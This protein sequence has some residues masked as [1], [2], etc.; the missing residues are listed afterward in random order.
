MR[1]HAI[2][3]VPV[4]SYKKG[5]EILVAKTLK[6]IKYHSLKLA[7]MFSQYPF[8]IKASNVFIPVLLNILEPSRLVRNLFPP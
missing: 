8:P 2:Q 7:K 6:Y 3:F 1:K 4:K 5:L